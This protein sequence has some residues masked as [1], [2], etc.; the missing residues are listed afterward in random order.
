MKIRLPSPSFKISSSKY[1]KSL[2]ERFCYRL[3]RNADVA[4]VARQSV[5][6][7]NIGLLLAWS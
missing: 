3:P 4:E 1:R 2:R 7:N 5:A 6:I